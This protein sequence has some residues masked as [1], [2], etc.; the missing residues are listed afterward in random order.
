[1]KSKQIGIIIL[2]VVILCIVCSCLSFLLAWP[3]IESGI[4][5]QAIT[6]YYEC[7]A[8]KDS[9]ILE[10]YPEQCVTGDGRRFVNPD[11]KV[12]PLN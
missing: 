1:M 12:E 4:R 11:Q 5:Y 7:A 9:M 6:D 10:S 3:R 2:V 8:D